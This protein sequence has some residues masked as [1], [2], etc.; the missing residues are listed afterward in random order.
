MSQEH[1]VALTSCQ[2]IPTCTRRRLTAEPMWSA[3]ICL[4]PDMTPSTLS[5]RSDSAGA[6][7]LVYLMGRP[8]SC[9]TPAGQAQALKHECNLHYKPCSK[10]ATCAATVAVRSQIIAVLC[11]Q[12]QFPYLARAHGTPDTAGAQPQYSAR[13]SRQFI[14]SA[15]CCMG[16]AAVCKLCMRSAVCPGHAH[17]FIS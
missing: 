11:V 9:N 13:A 2:D 3:N 10:S 16:S 1:G 17:S 5:M 15:V 4:S 8:G 12:A 6:I 14:S 7:L